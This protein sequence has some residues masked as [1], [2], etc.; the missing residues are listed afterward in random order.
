VAPRPLQSLREWF[1]TL[2]AAPA[3]TSKTLV[4]DNSDAA[5]EVVLRARAHGA[6]VQAV[7][8]DGE[9]WMVDVT[10]PANRLRDIAGA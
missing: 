4:T 3:L 5:W 1:A 8:R 6:S 2:F 10:A 9:K 7:R